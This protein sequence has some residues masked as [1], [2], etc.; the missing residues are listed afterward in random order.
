MNNYCVYKHISL[1]DDSI[2]YI[3]VGNEKRPYR[4][5]GRNRWW[6]N[7]VKKYGYKIEVLFNNLSLEEAYE[8]E[9]YLVSYYGR[10]DLKTGS[11][12]NLTD[13]GAGTKLISKSSK[14]KSLKL[15]SFKIIDISNNKVYDSINDCARKNKI[16]AMTL[17]RYLSGERKNKTNFRYLEKE[18]IPIKENSKGRNLPK[19]V[20]CTKTNI[21]WNSINKCSICNGINKLVLSDYLNGIKENKTT[22]KFLEDGK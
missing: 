15:R 18:N 19:K 6:K 13:G 9:I 3:G 2:F 16:G 1:K 5:D 20:I 8:I 12:C 10:L 11:L 17:S 7:I 14:K 21:I 4:K 22:F